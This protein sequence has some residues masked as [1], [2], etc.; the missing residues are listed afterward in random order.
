[1]ITSF[2]AGQRRGAGHGRH[3]SGIW[4]ARLLA[5]LAG[6]GAALGA[7]AGAAA[8]P[9]HASQPAH[10]SGYAANSFGHHGAATGTATGPVMAMTAAGS[11]PGAIAAPSQATAASS[12]R[13]GVESPT[14]HFLA[15]RSS[16]R[17]TSVTGSPAAKGSKPRSPMSGSARARSTAFPAWQ[18]WAV[19]A[20]SSAPACQAHRLAR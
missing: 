11:R 20:I 10:V 8:M 1:M 16:G 19:T 9:A 7:A 4:A 15:A 2:L 18:P 12:A 14:R 5:C 6:G 3:R 13:P 17:P